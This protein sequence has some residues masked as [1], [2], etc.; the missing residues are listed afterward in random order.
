MKYFALTLFS[1]PEIENYEEKKADLY[2]LARN[3]NNQIGVYYENLDTVV[4]NYISKWLSLGFSNDTILE[5]ASY[6]RKTSIRTLEGVDDK[7]QKF[8]KLGLVSVEALHSYLESVIATDKQIQE[9]LNKVSLPRKVNYLDREFYKTWTEN[10]NMPYD[11]ISYAASFAVGKIQPMQYINSILSS[12]N[13]KAVHTLEKAKAEKLPTQTAN[14]TPAKM[15]GG[16]SYQ[17]EEL[18]ALIQ[19]IDEVEI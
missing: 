18:D 1:I 2:N 5:I 6:C 9:I 15:S 8:F 13:Q 3:V 19:S 12:W 14:S 17:K 7:I 4:E 16:R 11:V 10:F